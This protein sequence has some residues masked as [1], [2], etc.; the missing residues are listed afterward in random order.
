MTTEHFDEHIFQSKKML[1]VEHPSED[2]QNEQPSQSEE[3]SAFS[4]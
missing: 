1:V 2:F 3:S 4:P